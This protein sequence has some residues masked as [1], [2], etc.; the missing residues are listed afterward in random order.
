[1]FSRSLLISILIYSKNSHTIIKTITETILDIIKY[2]SLGSASLNFHPSD[3][4]HVNLGFIIPMIKIMLA[5]IFMS[6][7]IS[8]FFRFRHLSYFYYFL[9]LNPDLMLLT[10]YQVGLC[11]L[12]NSAIYFYTL[13]LIY[14]SL[15]P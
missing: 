4:F 11:S 6:I 3:T 5:I 1:M 14:S 12:L 9:I 8:P 2:A 13:D 7:L 15:T 10:T